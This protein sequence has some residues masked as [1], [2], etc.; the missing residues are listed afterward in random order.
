M[1]TTTGSPTSPSV[2]HELWHLH[3]LVAGYQSI[4]HSVSSS[5]KSLTYV[6]RQS[7]QHSSAL[8]MVP[9]LG[10]ALL[11]DDSQ[12]PQ[13]VA[14]VLKGLGPSNFG[15]SYLYAQRLVCYLKRSHGVQ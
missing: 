2:S 12:M 11:R 4:A 14:V 3:T 7:S 9:E 1:I 13:L 15:V 6:L 5:K 8:L 10:D